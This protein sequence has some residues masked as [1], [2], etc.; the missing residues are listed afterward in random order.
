[1]DLAGKYEKSNLLGDGEVK[2][3]RG[4][5]KATR[6]AVLLHQLP[7]NPKLLR[8]AV[9][10]LIAKPPGS[11]LIEMGE[12]GE[13]TYLVTI[14][15]LELL[16]VTA[17]LEN[18]LRSGKTASGPPSVPAPVPAPPPQRVDATGP[19]PIP[20]ADSGP[21]P[22]PLADLGPAAKPA[23]VQQPGEFTR[24]FQIP[25][26]S[27]PSPRV[28]DPLAGSGS[29]NPF[30]PPTLRADSTGPVPILR[31]DSAPVSKPPAVQQ[32]GEFTR[33]FQLPTPS[34]PPPRPKD[35]MA[36][37]GSNQG[38]AKPGEFTQLFQVPGP[39]ENR[40][41]SNAPELG[42]PPSI[43]ETHSP[44][45]PSAGEF[46]RLFRPPAM[47]PNS[48]S[49][50]AQPTETPL[51]DLPPRQTFPPPELPAEPAPPKLSIP[52]G[53]VPLPE[54]S[55]APVPKGP[56]EY[57][58]I[59]QTQPLQAAPPQASAPPPPSLAQA[60]QLPTPVIATPS[61]PSTPYVQAPS[62]QA[63]SVQAPYVQAPYVQA[64]AVQAPYVQAPA[65]PQLPSS[66]PLP[67]APQTPAPAP[68]GPRK[69]L[70]PIVFLF[71]GLVL[72]ALVLILIFALRR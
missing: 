41:S 63:P 22:I 71:G 21:L 19:V 59:I 8:L 50:W 66:I 7:A 52:S 12:I 48:P 28:E 33:A 29:N 9:E 18:E 55:A 10:Y 4:R 17:W 56:G 58:R 53:P 65:V 13:A 57:T 23:P 31:M 54:S 40:A 26:S 30:S 25:G 49:P 68:R 69:G 6:A 20:R 36:G 60:V 42:L 44:S 47:A 27:P 14:S 51:R 72:V 67:A 37:A 45:T 5:D 2:V 46:T 24:A 64:P 1:M 3:W 16:D 15:E 35:P 34:A 11:P 39:G 61:L 32:P 62:V 70:S 43:P 38:S